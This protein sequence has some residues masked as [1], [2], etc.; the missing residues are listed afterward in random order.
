[1]TRPVKL[2]LP[3]TD[4]CNNAMTIVCPSD[5]LSVRLFVTRT[6]IYV[7]ISDGFSLVIR[8]RPT[9]TFSVKFSWW[10]PKDARV[11]KQSA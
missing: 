4:A 6:R 2:A 5:C 11:L 9:D 10:A 8:Y 7:S 3:D 1:M